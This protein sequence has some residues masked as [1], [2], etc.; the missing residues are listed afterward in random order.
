MGPVLFWDFITNDLS[1]NLCERSDF[2]P[3]NHLDEEAW[4]T[5]GESQIVSPR[6]KEQSEIKEL[7]K[8]QA[9]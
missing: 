9:L 8:T 3:I 5:D 4:N 2:T 1:P 6:I 7:N